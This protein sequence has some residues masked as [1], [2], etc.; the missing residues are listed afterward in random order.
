MTD[1]HNYTPDPPDPRRPT[2]TTCGAQRDYE[3]L[4]NTAFCLVCDDAVILDERPPSMTPWG[5]ADYEKEIATGIWVVGTPSHGGFWLSESRAN[6]MPSF[7]RR[8]GDQWAK[9]RQRYS[10]EW[11]EEDCCAASVVFTWQNYFTLEQVSMAR[12]M[13]TKAAPDFYPRRR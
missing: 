4:D 3:P 6:A 12:H 7:L 9:N 10:G 8:W 13:V 5:Q 11:H 2:C 1:G